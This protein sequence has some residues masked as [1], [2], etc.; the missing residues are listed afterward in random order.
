[1]PVSYRSI[2]VVCTMLYSSWLSTQ[3]ANA[4]IYEPKKAVVRGGVMVVMPFAEYE[5]S[6]IE[7]TEVVVEEPDLGVAGGGQMSA[8]YFVFDNLALEASLG[9]TS[10]SVGRAVATASSTTSDEST[11]S[12][13][14][15]DFNIQYHIAPY[16]RL[17]P[18]IG[19]GAGYAFFSQSFSSTPTFNAQLG[20][21]YWV[22]DN[23]GVSFNM[24]KYFNMTTESD[25]RDIY[26][27]TSVVTSG[28]TVSTTTTPVND[29]MHQE[30][31]LDPMV[32]T[33]GIGYRF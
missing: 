29:T 12:I 23:L 16:G 4:I 8:S 30:I 13:I 1:M 19:G 5:G 28:S 24:K 26:L 31:T 14:P 17:T 27:A 9:Y 25:K 10:Y 7:N 15:I 11:L 2:A 21:D 3:D 33:V 18:Y 6:L 20:F 32:M 22:R